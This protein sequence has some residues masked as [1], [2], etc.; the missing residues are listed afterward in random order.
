MKVLVAG[1]TGAVGSRLMAQLL[2]SGHGVLGLTR[3][4]G[5]GQRL[6]AV[7]TD[8]TV[9]DLLDTDGL[10][11]SRAGR[12]FD[13][14]IHQASAISEMP[15]SHRSLYATHAVRTRDDEPHAR[16][17]GGFRRASRI[18]AASS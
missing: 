9:V 4:E 6:T 17:I 3:S 18:A 14:I 11:S 7:G 12:A 13:A 16:R 8:S 5:G 15:A 2:A 1:A 10:L